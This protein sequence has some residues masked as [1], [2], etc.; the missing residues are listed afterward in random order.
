[1][2]KGNNR[3]FYRKPCLFL[4]VPFFNLFMFG[5]ALTFHYIQLFL[6]FTLFIFICLS[7]SQSLSLAKK[8]AA[9]HIS[10]PYRPFVSSLIHLFVK[11]FYCPGYA[12]ITMTG[13]KTDNIKISS[14]S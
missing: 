8:R 13:M 4:S 10:N 11:F 2:G 1:M 14:I 9:R 5:M 6:F 12:I 7:L 3:F